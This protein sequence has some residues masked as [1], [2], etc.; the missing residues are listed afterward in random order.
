MI[1]SIFG[2]RHIRPVTSSDVQPAPLP[3]SAAGMSRQ[4]SAGRDLLHDYVGRAASSVEE[5][6]KRFAAAAAAAL[7][8]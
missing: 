3:P 2:N 5:S 1:S 6:Q 7:R 4:L 8:R